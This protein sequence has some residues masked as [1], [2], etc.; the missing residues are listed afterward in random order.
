MSKFK[1]LVFV[2]LFILIVEI[3]L[4]IIEVENSKTMSSIKNYNNKK[5][6]VM[7]VESKVLS[8]F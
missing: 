8:V 5:P 3:L 2:L 1:K 4:I 7:Y 6:V